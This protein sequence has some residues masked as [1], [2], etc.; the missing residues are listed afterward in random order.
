MRT[1]K[2]AVRGNEMKTKGSDDG[3]ETARRCLVCGIPQ[4]Y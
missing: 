3:T 1:E 2:R 4:K